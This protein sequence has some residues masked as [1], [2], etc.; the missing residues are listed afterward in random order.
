MSTHDLESSTQ[1]V[2]R[3]PRPFCQPLIHSLWPLLWHQR[4][5][6][7]SILA[8]VAVFH[9]LFFLPLPV[10]YAVVFHLLFH[11][12]SPDFLH[13]TQIYFTIMFPDYFLNG[14]TM[15]RYRSVQDAH[16]SL[17]KYSECYFLIRKY[18][19]TTALFT[20]LS[21]TSSMTNYCIL[22]QGICTTFK[23]VF[24][25]VGM[26]P[27]QT[28]LFLL[29]RVNMQLQHFQNFFPPLFHLS[30]VICLQC[31]KI[32]VQMSIRSGIHPANE[33]LSGVKSYELFV[34]VNCTGRLEAD[35]SSIQISLDHCHT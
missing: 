19:F 16:Q 7:V 30:L 26:F 5:S 20:V 34:F 3:F 11:L 25:F 12:I 24:S 28:A 4:L 17:Q 1:P 33:L 9:D 21:F 10:H 14:H 2:S 29:H 6:C 15:N 8:F 18:V 23:Y 22:C 31:S 27:C 32:A 13:T 35:F